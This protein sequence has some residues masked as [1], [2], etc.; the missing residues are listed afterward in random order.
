MLTEK[1]FKEIK[2]KWH[3]HDYIQSPLVYD[4]MVLVI[5]FV[6]DYNKF[7]FFIVKDDYLQ[8]GNDD[9]Y[10]LMNNVLYFM[11]SFDKESS[12]VKIFDFVLEQINSGNFQTN[13]DRGI[14]YDSYVDIYNLLELNY[15]NIEHSS[16]TIIQ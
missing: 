3:R 14:K 9:F 1:E 10:Y 5:N 8:L 4:L 15:G 11:G 6:K 16:H 12:I 7:K 2:N 13:Y